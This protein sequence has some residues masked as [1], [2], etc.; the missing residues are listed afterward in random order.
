MCCI[1]ILPGASG[2]GCHHRRWRRLRERVLGGSS[3]QGGSVQ[4]SEPMGLAREGDG[5]VSELD[6]MGLH[7]AWRG[8]TGLRGGLLL[9]AAYD[10][11]TDI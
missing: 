9:R 4:H 1:S 2:P 7:G 3:G 6:A 8:G 11:N 10:C 5:A